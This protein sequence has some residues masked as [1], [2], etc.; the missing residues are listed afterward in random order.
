MLLM[1]FCLYL[2]RRELADFMVGNGS[3]S[4]SDGSSNSRKEDSSSSSSRSSSSNSSNIDDA[5]LPSNGNDA[6]IDLVCKL[7]LI[8]A[9]FQVNSRALF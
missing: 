4:M 9:L 2:K 7:A 1:A 3:S 8:A 6:V 5:P